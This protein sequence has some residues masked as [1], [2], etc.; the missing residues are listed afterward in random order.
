MM[1]DVRDF[2]RDDLSS[3]SVDN[4]DFAAFVAKYRHLFEHSPWVVERAWD[5]RPFPNA[6]ALH[7]AFWQ[8]IDRAADAERLSLVRAHPELANKDALN[9]GLTTSSRAEQASAG[10]DRLSDAEYEEFSALNA[11]YRKRFGFPFVICVRL[12]DKNSIVREL[13]SRLAGE[14]GAELIAAIC[15]VGL[16]SKLRLAQLTGA[17]SR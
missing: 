16:I 11:A 10:L 2:L 13:K 17:G 9:R 12:Q 4:G 7:D 6:A 3:L 14:P 5:M 8:V 1:T 15:Q